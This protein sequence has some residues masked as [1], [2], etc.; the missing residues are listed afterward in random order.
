MGEP[1]TELW[2]DESSF[3]PTLS[4]GSDNEV[5]EFIGQEMRRVE[6]AHS[7]YLLLVRSTETKRHLHILCGHDLTTMSASDV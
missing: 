4:S 2:N 5:D 6:M 3:S 1:V 7:F